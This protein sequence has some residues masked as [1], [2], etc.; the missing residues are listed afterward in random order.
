[1]TPGFAALLANQ[2]RTRRA[3]LSAEGI[4]ARKRRAAHKTK[5]TGYN[6]YGWAASKAARECPRPFNT[7]KREGRR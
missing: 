5:V 7:E 1:M 3:L 4:E 2:E 6:E